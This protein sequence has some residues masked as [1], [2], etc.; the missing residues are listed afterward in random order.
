MGRNSL[1]TLDVLEVCQ[2]VESSCA[3]L[4]HHFAEQFKEDRESFL[5]WLKLATEKENHAKL[6]GLVAKLKQNDLIDSIQIELI[7]AEVNLLYVQSLNERVR[8]N[9]PSKVEALQLAV[10][11]EKKVGGSMTANL[12]QSFENSFLAIA[13]TNSKQLELL[14]DMGGA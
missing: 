3:E 10:D 4:Y 1:G 2:K 6:F 14:R 12:D 11:L 13:G 5:L 7:D 8:T 9:P